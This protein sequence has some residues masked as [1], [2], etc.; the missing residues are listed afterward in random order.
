MFH[1]G[2]R[3]WGRLLIFLNKGLHIYNVLNRGSIG[4]S[5]IVTDAN[6][7][8]FGEFEAVLNIKQV[9]ATM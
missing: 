1:R 2:H 7:Q 6:W 3:G 5:F 4:D 8:Q 9:M